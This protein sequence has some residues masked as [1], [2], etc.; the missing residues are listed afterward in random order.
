MK[1]IFIYFAVIT[2][3][4]IKILNAQTYYGKNEFGK[5]EFIN[6]SVCTVSFLGLP[7]WDIVDTCSYIK[8]QDT[9]FLSSKIQQCEIKYRSYESPIGKG[10]P[11]LMKIYEKR[12]KNMNW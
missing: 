11:V 4:S 8:N 7:F 3:S 5:F 6:D 9:I 1:K 10:Y 2:L 12:Q